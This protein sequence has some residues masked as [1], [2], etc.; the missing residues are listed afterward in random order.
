VASDPNAELLDILDDAGLPSGAVKARG[1]VHRDGDW[2]RAIHIWVVREHDSVLIQRRDRR[3]EI[4]PGKLDVSV[5]GHLRSGE[6]ILDGLREAEE[7][8]G[9]TLRPGQLDFLMTVRSERRYPNQ[10]PAVVDREFQDVYVVRDERPLTEYLLDPQEVDTVYEVPLDRAIALFEVGDHVPAP[11][12][13][14]MRRVSNALLIDA[15]L[16]SQ[17]RE[18]LAAALR[19]LLEWTKTTAAAGTARAA[20]SPTEE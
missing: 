4:E 17:G 7:E 3:K 16:P 20:V 13:D 5:G 12:F 1:Q 9:L 14:A 6:T 19:Q 8:L 15:D 11:G 2:H 18:T 10:A